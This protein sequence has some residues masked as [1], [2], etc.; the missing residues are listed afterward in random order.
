MVTKADI[1]DIVKSKYSEDLRLKYTARFFFIEQDGSTFMCPSTSCHSGL[2]GSG[3]T[4]KA[5]VSIIQRNFIGSYTPYSWDDEYAKDAKIYLDWLCK[6]SP[7]AKAYMFKDVKWMLDNQVLP[8]KTNVPGWM[9]GGSCVLGRHIHEK[10][11]IIKNFALLVRAGVPEYMCLA[12]AN[13][14][15]ISGNEGFILNSVS[16]THNV[17][18]GAMT[19]DWL[20]NWKDGNKATNACNG[21]YRKDGNCYGWSEAFS[22]IERDISGGIGNLVREYVKGLGKSNDSKCRNPF[23][24]AK[25]RS[26]DGDPIKFN[27]GKFIEE[28]D[29]LVQRLEV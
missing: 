29:Q 9:V 26:R 6:R 21:I 28:I 19:L 11:Q 5:V 23:S 2:R 8:V 4:K 25:P 16:T 27:T 3:V 13:W 15:S 10:P 18:P 12:V 17:M 22:P 7:Y 14:V 1:V 24:K 20:R